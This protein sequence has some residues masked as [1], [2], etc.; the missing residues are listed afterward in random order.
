MKNLAGDLFSLFL[1]TS[2]LFGTAVKH[3]IAER[4]RTQS[5]QPRYTKEEII[6]HNNSYLDLELEEYYRNMMS[7]PAR[8]QEIWD[9]LNKCKHMFRERDQEKLEEGPLHIHPK[10]DAFPKHMPSRTKSEY[11]TWNRNKTLMLLMQTNL[12]CPKKVVDHH[13]ERENWIDW[14]HA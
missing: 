11:L 2:Y 6:R 4:K 1:G 10:P 3:N 9:I 13:N 5:A 7:D 8:E 14:I 12:K